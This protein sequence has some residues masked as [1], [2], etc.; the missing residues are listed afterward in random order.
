M[1]SSEGHEKYTEEA[2]RGR[3]LLVLTDFGGGEVCC[4]YSIR[5]N[6]SH[7]KDATTRRSRLNLH[8]SR[9]DV[10]SVELEGR[11]LVGKCVRLVLLR[12]R[13]CQRSCRHYDVT[14]LSIYQMKF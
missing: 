4:V 10:S 13:P 9:S 3:K 12:R 8:L 14:Q 6:H 7:V 11:K 5:I 1:R 2:E